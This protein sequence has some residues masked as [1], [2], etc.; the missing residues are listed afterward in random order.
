M[1]GQGDEREVRRLRDV[2]E[3]YKAEQVRRR[4][5]ADNPGNR[6]IV[7]ERRVMARSLLKKH[8]FVPL[9]SRKVL[10]IGCGC[11][12]KLARLV[13]WGARPENLYGVDLLADRIDTAQRTYPKIHFRCGNA[14][15]LDW[16][17]DTFDLVLLFTVFSSILSGVMADNVAREIRR[18]L[19]PGGGVL[20]YDIRF[21]NPRN[22]HVRGITKRQLRSWFPGFQMDLRSVTLL[23]LLARRLGKL[24]PVAYPLLSRL[25]CL[26]TH[27]LG[28]LIKP[29]AWDTA[30]G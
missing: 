30:D 23:P 19:K 14:E 6:A 9:A 17:D 29:K 1:G 26:R 13:E 4:W 22:P 28:L 12:G 8:G 20:W 10:D 3:S 21:D 16:D 7:D 24:T 27:Y 11:G 25:T 5:S 2:Y 18:V 15:S